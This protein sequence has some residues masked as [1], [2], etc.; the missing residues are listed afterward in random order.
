MQWV[1]AAREIVVVV[2]P[3]KPNRLNIVAQGISNSLH[4][5]LPQ[6]L[7]T[8]LSLSL[9]RVGSDQ[10]A[11]KQAGGVHYKKRERLRSIYTSHTSSGKPDGVA[12]HYTLSHP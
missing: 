12:L 2:R 11:G 5:S 3:I 1:L 7:Y 9:S 8:S 10:A 4:R 6:P